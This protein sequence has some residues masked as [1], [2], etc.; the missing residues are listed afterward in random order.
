[1]VVAR[2]G[3]GVHGL[4]EEAPRRSRC[5]GRRLADDRIRAVC[6]PAPRRLTRRGPSGPTG[7]RARTTVHQT[8]RRHRGGDGGRALSQAGIASG[9]SPS[10]AGAPRAFDVCASG[11]RPPAPVARRR[12][13]SRLPHRRRGRAA[14]RPG[15]G[16][17]ERAAGLSSSPGTL[18]FTRRAVATP[19][20]VD[21][22]RGALAQAR[23]RAPRR[24]APT[25]S[26]APRRSRIRSRSSSCTACPRT[27]PSTSGRSRRSSKNRG[28]C[29]FSLTYGTKDD[30]KV[31]AS[32][33]PAA[34]GRYSRA[35][36]SSSASSS[37][38]LR[39]DR[40]PARSP[41]SGTLR[42]A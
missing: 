36:A 34:C 31:P 2:L 6:S 29:V 38:V 33:S 15:R 39:R 35:P 21:R 9:L 32:T 24:P 5:C 30:V 11:P 18:T 12:A 19:G 40:R 41:S 27:R 17:S 42:A 37:E 23:L 4:G 26:T 13:R 16:S 1:M 8:R 14:R 25:T 10:S 20:P 22:R 28:F 7:C 3:D